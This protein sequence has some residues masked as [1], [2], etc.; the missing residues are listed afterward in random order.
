MDQ[1]K[2][3][4][5][6]IKRALVNRYREMFVSRLTR[7]DLKE[8]QSYLRDQFDPRTG[9]NHQERMK[10]EEK[11]RRYF[12]EEFIRREI[13]GIEALVL[14]LTPEDLTTQAFP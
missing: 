1:R 10:F 2:I 8:L 13:S 7:E 11:L 5:E 4:V 12:H 3:P 9:W 14:L 6:D